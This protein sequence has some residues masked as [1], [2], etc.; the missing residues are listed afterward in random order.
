MGPAS[1]RSAAESKSV[2]DMDSNESSGLPIGSLNPLCRNGSD[3]TTQLFKFDDACNI[4]T[5][6]RATSSVLAVESEYK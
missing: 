6:L 5:P 2:V 3:T 4:N 1:V